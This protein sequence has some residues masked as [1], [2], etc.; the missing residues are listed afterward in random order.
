M[1]GPGKIWLHKQ[2]AIRAYLDG[3]GFFVDGRDES[4]DIV[5]LVDRPA[6]IIVLVGIE[7]VAMIA[8]NIFEFAA[9]AVPPVVGMQAVANGLV[10]GALRVNIERR[11]DAKPAFMDGFRAVSAFQIFANLL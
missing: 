4:R 2:G 10:R 1:P 11:V 7:R 6:P 5:A 8:Q 3:R 9:P